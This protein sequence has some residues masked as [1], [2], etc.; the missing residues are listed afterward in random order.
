MYKKNLLLFLSSIVFI[1]SCHKATVSTTSTDFST[2]EQTV[3][4]DFTNNTALP[5]YSN[6]VSAAVSLNSSIGNFKFSNDRC[7]S[8]N[9]TIFLEEYAQYMGTMRRIF[10]GTG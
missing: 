9:R 2:T 4:S 8:F 5:Q 10:I 3:I 6:L 1:A 7:E